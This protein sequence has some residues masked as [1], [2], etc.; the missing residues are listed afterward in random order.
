MAANRNG[1]SGSHR[2]G[3]RSILRYAR[4]CTI[5]EDQRQK[6]RLPI[7]ERIWERNPYLNA[8][9]VPLRSQNAC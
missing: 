1:T 4:L 7:W 6:T 2:A 8:L 5:R 9:C 3:P